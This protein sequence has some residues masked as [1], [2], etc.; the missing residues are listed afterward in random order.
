M[1]D[2]WPDIALQ[3]PDS[4]NYCP[5]IAIICPNLSSISPFLPANIARYSPWSAIIAHNLAINARI[6]PFSTPLLLAKEPHLLAN[7][8]QN[9]KCPPLLL[10]KCPFYSPRSANVHDKGPKI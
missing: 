8:T 10:T 3:M 6:S 9:A 4:C 1:Q 7:A 2:S 5:D